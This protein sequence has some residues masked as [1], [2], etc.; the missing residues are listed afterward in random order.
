MFGRS[1]VKRQINKT[2]TTVEQ[3]TYDDYGISDAYY[4]YYDF[5]PAFTLIILGIIVGIVELAVASGLIALPFLNKKYVCIKCK[6][7]FSRFKKPKRCPICNGQVITEKE[8]LENKEV[9]ELFN[10]NNTY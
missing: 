3:P 7:K 2:T 8:Y 1:V 4:Y 6:H 5:R 9:L 10:K